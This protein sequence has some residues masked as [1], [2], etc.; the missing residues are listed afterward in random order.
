M[1]R[2]TNFLVNLYWDNT[3]SDSD[4]DSKLLIGL[5]QVK[6]T[7]FGVERIAVKLTVDFI[8]ILWYRCYRFIPSLTLV[9]RAHHCVMRS[10]TALYFWGHRNALGIMDRTPESFRFCV[11][12]T[13][14]RH[15]NWNAC[16]AP[17]VCISVGWT[18]YHTLQHWIKILVW[19]RLF[20]S[21]G[22]KH[23]IT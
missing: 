17:I 8:S 16:L 19:F 18:F 21:L 15:V 10:L 12:V 23:L 2:K 3:Y 11:Q 13:E 5:K 22:G 4:S 14:E 20:L 7:R 1:Y 9:S 6:R